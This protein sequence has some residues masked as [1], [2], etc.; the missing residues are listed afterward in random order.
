MFSIDTETVDKYLR[1]NV[2]IDSGKFD[3]G[4]HNIDEAWDLLEMLDSVRVSIGYY[5]RGETVEKYLLRDA[6]SIIRGLRHNDSV[7]DD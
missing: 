1:V 6:E 5:L 3:L 4:L 7:K 2:A